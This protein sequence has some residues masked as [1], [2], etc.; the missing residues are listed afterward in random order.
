MTGTFYNGYASSMFFTLYRTQGSFRETTNYD[1]VQAFIQLYGLEQK[2]TRQIKREGQYSWSGYNVKNSTRVKEIPG[3]HP[4]MIALM[5]PY[6]IFMKIEDFGKPEYDKAEFT[7]FTDLEKSTEKK[8]TSYLKAIKQDAIAQMKSDGSMS[9]MSQ[10]TWAKAAVYDVY[11]LGD[12]VDGHGLPPINPTILAPKEEALLRLVQ[13]TKK[14]GYPSLIFYVQTDRRPIHN[15]LADWFAKYGMKLSY[16][17][18]TVN[19]RIEFIDGALAHGADAVLCN[20]NLVRE[21]IDL[22]QFGAIVWYGVTPDAILVDQA[23]AR[24]YRPLIQNHN[25]KMFYLGY[26]GT[27]QSEQWT[28]TAK[29]VAAMSA[30]HGDI[31][32]GLAALL[33]EDT[34]ITTVQDQLIQYKKVDS[35]L[36]MEDLPALEVWETKV[37]EKVEEEPINV[38]EEWVA[39]EYDNENAIQLSLF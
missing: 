25:V 18:S 29:K 4:A 32:K 17:P 39:K 9:L 36:T 21:G 16:M 20:P 26:N 14:E 30:V 15:R 35:Q 37:Q 33:G 6:T 10:L 22:L 34:L 8:I 11:P 28:T 3:I 7:L 27:Y 13:W 24:I 2:I 23:N 19:K 12:T 1:D 38:T 31:R 5:L